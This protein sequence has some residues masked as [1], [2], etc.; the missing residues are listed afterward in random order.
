MTD[1]SLTLESNGPN[2]TR[3]IGTRLG[4]RLRPGNVVLL[5]GD[6][7]AGKTTF[8]QGIAR[9]LGIEEPITSP[10]FALINEYAG[11]TSAG[12]Q[13]VFFHADLYRVGPGDAGTLGLEDYL[14]APDTVGVI[15]W[16]QMAPAI[17]PATALTVTIDAGD[18]G[19]HRRLILDVLGGEPGA[20]ATSLDA[21]AGE[22]GDDW[23]A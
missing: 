10:T 5:S 3:A 8:T 19:D 17:L 15:E 12:E 14:S 20:Q 6:L 18:G 16:P 13:V 9:G 4:R 7:G 23:S 21:L 22:V 11:M 1:V 2:Q